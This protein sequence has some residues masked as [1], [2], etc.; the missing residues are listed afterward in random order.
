VMDIALFFAVW[1]I[2]FIAV[3]LWLNADLFRPSPPPDPPISYPHH[4]W[5]EYR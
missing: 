2:G 3:A 4:W 5:D 1:V